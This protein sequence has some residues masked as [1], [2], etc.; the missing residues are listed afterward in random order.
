MNLHNAFHNLNWLAIL[1][2]AVSSFALGFLWYSVLFAKRWMKENGFSDDFNKDA[3]MLKIFGL[4][5]LLM[6]FAA[7]TLALFIGRGVGAHY[8][9]MV[10]FHAGLGFAFTMIGV[11]YLFERKSLALFLINGCYSVVSLTIMGLIIGLMQ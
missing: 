5:F 3:N 9:A 2:A 8:G 7:F 6:L 10:G 11:I 1:L 4:S